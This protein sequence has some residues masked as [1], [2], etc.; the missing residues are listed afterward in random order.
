MSS[1][2]TTGE[3]MFQKSE[4][5]VKLI[6]AVFAVQAGLTPAIKGSRNPYFKS[7]YADLSACW[8]VVGPLL[9]A[10]DLIL[11]QLPGMSNNIP[12]LNSILMHTSGEWIADETPLMMDKANAQG[13]GSAV[14]YTRRYAMSALLGLL[15]ADDDGAAASSTVSSD[16]TA[17]ATKAPPAAKVE[18]TP[19][20]TPSPTVV[21]AAKAAIKDDVAT[22]AMWDAIKNEL[23]QFELDDTQF[24]NWCIA[25][26]RAANL[27]VPEAMV[28]LPKISAAHL[29]KVASASR[30]TGVPLTEVE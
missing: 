19:K 1:T 11:M 4:T 18:K 8:E 30:K 24:N 7:N 20:P 15:S 6:K 14:T 9:Q 27:V 10:N 25:S 12:T 23:T 22:P 5:T 29:W 3:Y 21:E 2:S 16:K 28:D 17:P 13:F 26:L